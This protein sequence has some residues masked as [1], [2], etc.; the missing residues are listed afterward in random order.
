MAVTIQEKKGVTFQEKKAGHAKFQYGRH[1][2]RWPPWSILNPDLLL[3][4]DSKWSKK[5]TMTT[6]RML[7]VRKMHS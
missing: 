4:N 6:E 2:P 7:L 3:R 1:F 5:I